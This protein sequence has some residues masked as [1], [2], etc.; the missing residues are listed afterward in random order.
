MEKT[1]EFQDLEQGT[2]YEEQ[3]WVGQVVV[4]RYY[5]PT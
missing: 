1:P 4:M 2:V 5:L 3:G